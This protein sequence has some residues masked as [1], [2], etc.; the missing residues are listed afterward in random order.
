MKK[1]VAILVIML[2]FASCYLYLG[3]QTWESDH[4]YM[5]NDAV[6]YHGILY[7]SLDNSNMNNEPDLFPKIWTVV[8]F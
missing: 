7:Q 6:W 3:Y 2:F 1:L 4:L 5:K 8:F